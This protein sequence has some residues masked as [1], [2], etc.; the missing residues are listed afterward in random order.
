[1]SKTNKN[2]TIQL[3]Y[4]RILP[5]SEPILAPFFYLK[6]K[7]RKF[8]VFS[9]NSKYKLNTECNSRYQDSGKLYDTAFTPYFNSPVLICCII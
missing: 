3:Y 7:K 5:P 6:S 2:Y 1:M 4:S 9:A 8:V